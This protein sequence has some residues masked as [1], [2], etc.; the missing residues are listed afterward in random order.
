MITCRYSGVD[1]RK[2]AEQR[3]VLESKLKHTVGFL[4]QSP[5]KGK[6]KEMYALRSAFD[7]LLTKDAET[8]IRFGRPR[9]YEHGD[10]PG[11]Y[12]AYLTN[13]K[14]DSQNITSIKDVNGKQFFDNTSINDIFRNFYEDL[15]KSRIQTNAADI[16]DVFFASL[17]LP[18]L[19]EDQN[20][21]PEPPTLFPHKTIQTLNGWFSSFVWAGRKP[22]VKMVKC[23]YL[24]SALLYPRCLPSSK[25]GL[26][27]PDIRKYQLS[28]HRRI[29]ADWI[30][31]PA[32][33]WLDIESSMSSFPLKSLC[34]VEK[35]KILRMF[36]SN[37][38]TLCT[39]RAWRMVQKLEERSHLT[40]ISLPYPIILSFC[41]GPRTPAFRTGL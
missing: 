6:L 9:L 14:S 22:C 28:T 16:L 37:P 27:F 41:L 30:Q 15:Y 21:R 32:P 35:L 13:K 11:K 26:D 12:L 7:C 5:S 3:Q 19:S 31:Q 25:G 2:Q 29:A 39:V 4:R 8:K 33:V 40:S 34:F 20:V 24:Y 36:C 17:N 10:K 18:K 1:K 23:L 38:L